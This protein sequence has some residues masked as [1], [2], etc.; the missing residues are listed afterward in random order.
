MMKRPALKRDHRIEPQSG[1][2]RNELEKG[3]S[4]AVDR[5]INTIS[6]R[7]KTVLQERL[8]DQNDNMPDRRA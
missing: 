3:L 5:S 1:S 8:K 6:A 7:L 4:E 2:E